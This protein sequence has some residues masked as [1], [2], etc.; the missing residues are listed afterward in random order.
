M[1]GLISSV[2]WVKR[3]VS[4]RYPNKYVLDEKELER[5]SALARIELEDARTELERA[6]EAAKSMGRGAEGDEADDADDENA[7]VDDD[8]DA[9]DTDQDPPAVPKEKKDDDLSEYKLDEY[10]NEAKVSGTGPFSNIKGLTYYRDNDEDPYITFKEEEDDER[11][12]LEVL[13]TDN[14]LVAAKTEDEISQLEIYVYDESQENLYIHHDLMLPNFPLCLEWLDFP[15]ASSSTPSDTSTKQF[16]N[17][18]AVGTMDPEIEIWSLDVV[19]AMY[20]DMVLGRP[21]KTAAHIPTPVGTG[22]KKRKKMKQRPLSDLHHVDGVLSI[23]WNKTHRNM[24]ASGSAD[25]T[26]KLWDLSRGSA[27]NSEEGSA[28]ASAIRSFAVHKDKVQAV[29]WNEKEPTVLLSGSYDRT[30]RT[31]DSRAPDAGVGAVL[32][33]DVEALRWDPWESHAF[34]VSL[35]NGLVLNFDARTLPSNLNSPSPS[36]FTLSAHDGAASALDVNP[37]IRGCLCTGGA[38]KLVKVWNVEAA[39]DGKPNVSMVA[40]RDLEVGKVFSAVFSPDD[41]LTVAA[42]GTR[43]KL[44]IWDIGSNFGARKTFA[45][46]LAEAGRILKEKEGGGIVGVV[47][48]ADDDSDGE[49]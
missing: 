7:W 22:K 49:D 34:Y 21:D 25:K 13:P 4:A 16:G 39:P 33:A 23:S 2:S 32:G 5:V 40:S 31:F 15:P 3:G 11:E 19:E 8:N 37:H 47:D 35:E 12:D 29:H 30:V 20:P 26:V 44:Q 1:S 6:H 27:T 43:G 28:A 17:Y 38:D 46:K 10:D 36:R 9:M 18:I 41:P 45:S 14:L 24:L 48:E 42:A